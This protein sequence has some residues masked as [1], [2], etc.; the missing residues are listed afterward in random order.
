MAAAGG[1]T[2]PET[3]TFLFNNPEDADVV[4]TLQAEGESGQQEEHN[5]N[6]DTCIYLHSAA[7]RKHSRFFDALLSE[8]W[9]ENDAKASRTTVTLKGCEDLGTVAYGSV[10]ECMYDMEKSRYAPERSLFCDVESA[11][12]IFRATDRLE[13]LSLRQKALDF[14]AAVPWNEEEEE[15]IKELC[16]GDIGEGIQPLQARLAPK[17][18]FSDDLK[19]RILSQLLDDEDYS[20]HVRSILSDLMEISAFED[21]TLEKVFEETLG[22]LRE[23]RDDM[24]NA[25]SWDLDKTGRFLDSLRLLMTAMLESGRNLSPILDMLQEDCEEGSGILSMNY[26]YNDHIKEWKEL[27]LNHFYQNLINIAMSGKPPFMNAQRA[28]VVKLWSPPGREEYNQLDGKTQLREKQVAADVM[29]VLSTLLPSEQESI[30]NDWLPDMFDW[31]AWVPWLKG[32][33]RVSRYIIL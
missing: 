30:Y 32:A 3:L 16:K 5:P 7:L 29:S 2:N 33:L 31:A 26:D 13:M 15:C 21:A 22:T 24:N 8:R 19:G 18:A 11:I 23:W 6:G 4:L 25:T 27:Y 17:P 12:R 20:Q 10:L 14:L 9:T 1:T 28:L